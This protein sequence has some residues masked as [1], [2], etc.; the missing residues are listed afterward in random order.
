MQPLTAQVSFIS[1]SQFIITERL[2]DDNSSRFSQGTAFLDSTLLQISMRRQALKRCAD[3]FEH[4]ILPAWLQRQAPSHQLINLRDFS[5]LQPA[6]MQSAPLCSSALSLCPQ[7]RA[8]N[9]V[10]CWSGISLLK[11]ESRQPS[12]PTHTILQQVRYHLPSIT[13]ISRNYCSNE[14][15]PSQAA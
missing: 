5:C 2:P 7:L 8:F 4:Q 6:T 3:Y 1:V 14:R 13:Y 9:S 12:L 15:L 10:A 11:A